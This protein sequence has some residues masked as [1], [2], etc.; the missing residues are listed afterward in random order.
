MG[1]IFS[2]DKE[3][4]DK[5]SCDKLN[6]EKPDGKKILDEDFVKIKKPEVPI[7]FLNNY[8]AKKRL[9]VIYESSEENEIE[10]YDVDLLESDKKN[11]L[12]DVCGI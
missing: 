4:N 12:D 1:L 2:Y 10:K 9:P 5:K 6:S 3:E 8:F 11:M 7:K